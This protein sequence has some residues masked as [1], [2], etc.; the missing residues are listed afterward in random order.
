VNGELEK[1]VRILGTAANLRRKV[2]SPINSADKPDYDALL[3]LL[4]E[5]LGPETFQSVWDEGLETP[6]D[7]AI[8]LALDA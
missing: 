1:A 8:Q 5:R 2:N 3:S 4:R 6:L 7:E